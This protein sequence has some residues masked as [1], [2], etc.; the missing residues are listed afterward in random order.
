[1][2]EKATGNVILR[3]GFSRR[4]R[5]FEIEVVSGFNA[6]SLEPLWRR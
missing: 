2:V 1:M 6:Q 4:P 5:E 3:P